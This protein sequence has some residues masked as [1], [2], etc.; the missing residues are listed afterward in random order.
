MRPLS[1]LVSQVEL[2]PLL[3]SIS[4]LFYFLAPDE[5]QFML[6]MAYGQMKQRL[7]KNLF[8]NRLKSVAHILKK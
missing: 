8:K 3:Y 5:L 2:T 1:S 7:K 6:N 4:S